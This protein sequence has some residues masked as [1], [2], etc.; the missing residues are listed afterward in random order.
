MSIADVLAEHWSISTHTD[1]EPTVDKCDGCGAVV[2]TW[3]GEWSAREIAQH[4]AA[5]LEAAGF[6]DVREAKAQ[7]LEEAA[8]DRAARSETLFN[9][10]KSI[11]SS[12]ERDMDDIVRYGAYSAEAQVTS[13]WLRKQAHKI[14][15]AGK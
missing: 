12:K 3:G 15:G 5:M 14:R 13:F 8:D 1:S 7:A 2:Y 9:T 11:V 10:M 4:Q 6:G